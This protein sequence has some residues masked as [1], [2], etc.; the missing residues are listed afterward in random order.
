MQVKADPSIVRAE[1][2]LHDHVGR[3]EDGDAGKSMIIE[4]RTLI[5]LEFDLFA[6]I[7]VFVAAFAFHISSSTIVTLNP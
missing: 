1:V 3:E 6:L 4:V 5:N 7:F 2:A